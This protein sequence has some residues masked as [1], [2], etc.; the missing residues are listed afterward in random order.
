[1]K[2]CRLS[3]P[4][5]CLLRISNQYYMQ[6]P[7]CF[8]VKTMR[9]VNSHWDKRTLLDFTIKLIILAC[10]RLFNLLCAGFANFKDKHLTLLSTFTKSLWNELCERFV[11]FGGHV[12]T[13]TGQFALLI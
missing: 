3:I 12:V 8:H 10:Y 11:D 4:T 13:N 2:F 6:L 1:M 5:F 9:M 7:S